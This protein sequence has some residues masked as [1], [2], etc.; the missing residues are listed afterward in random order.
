M[1]AINDE[2][3]FIWR[4]SI[5][6]QV[7][8]IHCAPAL[9][10]LLFDSVHSLLHGLVLFTPPQS[11]WSHAFPINA[12]ERENNTHTICVI[13]PL[14]ILKCI[15]KMNDWLVYSL[16]L[17]ARFQ[18]KYIWEII[19][20]RTNKKKKSREKNGSSHSPLTGSEC[21]PLS[22]RDCTYLA[23]VSFVFVHKRFL[24]AISTVGLRID[25]DFFRRK[26]KNK[27]QSCI[28]INHTIDTIAQA[29][30]PP[31]ITYSRTNK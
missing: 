11:S 4:A 16:V 19:E 30:V 12:L 18:N 5:T 26:T 25:V 21:E 6:F 8:Q 9:R 29:H 1:I 31:C 15:I 22:E 7:F 17:L 2:C 23:L 14:R 24:F 27:K 3:Y 10:Q 20:S 13:S 28:R